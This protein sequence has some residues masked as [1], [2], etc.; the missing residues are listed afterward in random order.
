MTSAAPE[1]GTLGLHFG[2]RNFDVEDAT[3]IRVHVES[4]APHLY[5]GSDG[6][7]DIRRDLLQ[8]LLSLMNEDI[9]YQL[10]E[11]SECEVRIRGVSL[12]VFLWFR[13]W[14][15]RNKPLE[16]LDAGNGYDD[17]Y[18]DCFLIDFYLF[19]YAPSSDAHLADGRTMKDLRR[20]LMRCFL[21]RFE[22]GIT[23]KEVDL[24]KLYEKA[25]DDPLVEFT[26]PMMLHMKLESDIDLNEWAKLTYRCT[27]V[28]CQMR[29]KVC[30]QE[31]ENVLPLK[32][33][34]LD[35]LREVIM[36]LWSEPWWK[37]EKKHCITLAAHMNQYLRW[38]TWNN[39]RKVV[40]E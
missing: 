37:W 12:Q 8:Q 32:D 4:L 23:P 6:P 19:A 33:E 11:I 3:S 17:R 29:D 24:R 16:A 38:I 39:N 31:Q 34:E 36:K 30:L 15:D 28:I 2:N 22:R 7:L 21:R 5:L 14:V 9:G 25:E 40:V 1:S 18:G 27:Y 26:I 10:V 20:D 35:S 13:D